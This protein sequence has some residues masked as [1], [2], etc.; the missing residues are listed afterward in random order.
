[1]KASFRA[2]N[3]KKIEFALT[4]TMSLEEWRELQAQLSEKWPSWKLSSHI[5]DMV[6]QA[7]KTFEVE[8]EAA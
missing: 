2:T 1:M 3:P 8:D 6:L 4:V 5:T 7:Q